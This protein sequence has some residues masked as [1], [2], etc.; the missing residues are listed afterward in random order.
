MTRRSPF[1]LGLFPSF[2]L[3]PVALCL[4]V[5]TASAQPAREWPSE[6]PPRPLPARSV[7]FPPYEVRTLSNGMQVVTVLHHEQP[8]VNIRLLVR[9]G[10]AQIGRAHV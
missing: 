9:A 8:A 3:I 4:G 5:L 10:A 2:V 6:G 7:K 1:S